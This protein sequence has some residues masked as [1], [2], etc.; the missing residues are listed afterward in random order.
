MLFTLDQV[1]AQE[2]QVVEVNCSNITTRSAAGAAAA[3]TTS[4]RIQLRFMEP[5]SP[6]GGSFRA[7]SIGTRRRRYPDAA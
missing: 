4:H 6:G 3:K 1:L 7:L 2:L 5:P